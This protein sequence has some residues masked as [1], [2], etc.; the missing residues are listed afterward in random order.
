V[1]AVAIIGGGFWGSAVSRMLVEAQVEH[2]VVDDGNCSGASRN[3]AGICKLSWYRQETVRRMIDGVFSYADFMD[4]WGWLQTQV[5][6]DHVPELF[7]NAPRGTSKEHTDN[8]LADPLALLVPAVGGRVERLRISSMNVE[9]VGTGIFAEHVIVCAGAFT[10]ALLMA[11]ELGRPTGV[12]PL[13]GRAIRFDCDDFEDTPRCQTV[14]TRPYVHY[15][16]RHMDG[17][18]RGGDTVERGQRNDRHIDNLIATAT[19]RYRGMRNME[20]FGGIRPV[21]KRM[22][23]DKVHPRVIAATGGH[24]VGFGLSGAVAMRVMDLL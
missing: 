24:R 12:Q 19:P 23:V 8:F 20:V 11:S 14:M 3:A 16:Y 13:W 2:V 22:F 1:V 21:C 9:L 18:I 6:I 5:E 7:V 10:D 4:G 15:T 17:R